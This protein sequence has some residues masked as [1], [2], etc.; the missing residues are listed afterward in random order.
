MLRFIAAGLFLVL[1]LILSIPLFLAEWI[2]GKS[3]PALRD[4]SSLRIVQWGFC[5]IGRICG[6]SVQVIGQERVPQDR[7]VL[8]VSNHR[9]F[10]D[11]IVTYPLCRSL[12]GYVSKK[13]MRKVPL[14]SH[15]MKL[16]YCLFLDRSDMRDGVRM[17]RDAVQNI[18]NGISVMIYP[19][20]TRGT[21]ETEAEMLPFH[22]GSFK[23]ATRSGCPVVP[24]AVTGSS[25]IFDDHMPRISPGK[26]T[27]EF[28]EPILTDQLTREEQRFLGKRVQQEIRGMLIKNRQ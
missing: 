18:R 26:V 5:V 4:K 8:Y 21:G 27:V 7:A 14:L 12:T 20:G 23:I 25:S 13:E 11:I 9:G 24:V 16:L 1:F 6:V 17:I 3:N 19:E 22:E 28:G 2:I 10:F 15:W